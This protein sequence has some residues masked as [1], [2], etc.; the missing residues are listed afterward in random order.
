MNSD[1]CIAIHALVYLK[2]TK[3]ILSSEDLSDNICTNSARIRKVMSKLKKAGLVKTKSGHIG[4]Y[5]YPF[6]Q[7]I[8]LYEISMAL[9]DKIVDMRWRSGSEDKA[10]LISSGMANIMDNL[11]G[12]LNYICL[13][14]LKSRN[15]SQI[16]KQLFNSNV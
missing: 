8:S 12:D 4:G 5:S 9:N 6:G 14:N 3:E 15:I 1:Y 7:E 13:D 10:C 16:E 11:I 2:H